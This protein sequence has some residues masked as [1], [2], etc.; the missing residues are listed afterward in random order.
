MGLA[1]EEEGADGEDPG[2]EGYIIPIPIWCGAA[3]ALC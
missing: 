1:L 3:P 2:E